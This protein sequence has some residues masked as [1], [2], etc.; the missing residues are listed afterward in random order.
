MKSKLDTMKITIFNKIKEALVPLLNIVVKILEK[1][2]SWTEKNPQLASGIAMAIM[3]ITGLVGAFLILAPIISSLISLG[4]VIIAKLL[5]FTAV[6]GA[7][8]LVLWDLWNGLTTGE[9]YIFAIIDGF[10]EWIGIGITLQ[11]IIDGIK[12]VFELLMN[13]VLNDVVPLIIE[14]WKFLCDSIMLFMEALQETIAVIIDI[15]VA[16]FTGNIPRAAEGFEQLKNI[17]LNIFDTMVSAAANAVSNILNMFADGVSKIGDML[18]GLPFGIGGFFDGIAK[19]AEGKIR[20]KANGVKSFANKLDGNV[21]KR[22]N[23]IRNYSGAGNTGKNRKKI[24]SNGKQ[25]NDV[26]PYR[27]IKNGSASP[28]N[29]KG[30]K[31]GGGGKKPSKS[32]KGGGGNSKGKEKNEE[33][34]IIVSAIESLQDVLKKTGYSITSEIKRANLFEVKRKALLDSQ[35]KEGVVELFR[36]MKERYFGKNGNTEN[37]NKIEIKFDSNGRTTNFNGINENTRLGE[38]YKINNSRSGG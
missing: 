4:G 10:L 11:E 15:I 13:F 19:G 26:D 3:A 16:L 29:S 33:N 2:A 9:S 25:K 14:A 38:I 1:I 18:S 35:K 12:M 27:N 32:G 21:K 28:N 8:I 23:D 17:V 34:K 22:K 20:Q 36:S 24:P 31:G 30:G 37:Y 5:V 6:I 7:V